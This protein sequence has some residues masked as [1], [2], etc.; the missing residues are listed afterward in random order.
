MNNKLILDACCGGRMFWFDKTHAN[1]LFIDKRIMPPEKVGHGR[2]ERTRKCLPDK[3]MDFRRMELPDNSFNLV[4]FDPPHLFL[5]ENSHTA[6]VY[7]S[8]SKD[9]WQKDL[10]AGFLECFRVLKE[11][12]V[13]IFKWNEFNIPLKEILALTPEKPLFGHRSGKAAKTHW[14]T[15]MKIKEGSK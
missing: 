5:G 10:R 7:G 4:V 8:L 11:N 1:T 2:H 3:V 15:F 9:N 12:G 13:L 6:K 14:V